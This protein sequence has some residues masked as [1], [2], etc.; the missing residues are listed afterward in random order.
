MSATSPPESVAVLGAGS[1]GTALAIQ[2]ARADGATALWGR[3]QTQMRRMA[4]ERINARYLP[5]TRLPEQL[6]IE[7]DL[8]RAA[9]GYR[10]LLICVP[11]HSFRET[12]AAIAPYL[13]A[14]SRV[15]W[16]TKGFEQQTGKLPHEVVREILGDRLPL[17]VL[18]GPTFAGEVAAGLPTAMTVAASHE[19]FAEELATRISG[20]GFRAY[21]SLDMIGVEVGGAVKNVLAIAA[22]VS[23]GLGYGANARVAVITRGLFEMTRLGV[24]LGA[25]AETFMGLSGI[26]DLVLTCTDDQSRNRRLGLALAR[27]TSPGDAAREIGFVV[28]GVYAARAVR[29]VAQ[30]LGVEMPICALVYRVLYEGMTPKDAVVALMSRSIRPETAA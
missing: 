7:P 22:G 23:D 17:A 28:E 14:D 27:G 6:V 16:A 10:T 29:E 13:G 2:L 3:D 18:S 20:H 15:A 26:G 21:S 12:V 1:W 5:G 8:A 11:S 30:R 4:A 9:R 25:S 19:H 24:A